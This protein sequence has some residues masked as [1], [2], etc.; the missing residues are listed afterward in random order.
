MYTGIHLYVSQESYL[1][2]HF[3]LSFYLKSVLW[4]ML[5]CLYSD[6]Y[7][8]YLWVSIISALKCYTLVV[9][10][11]LMICLICMPSAL[12]PAALRL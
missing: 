6:T 10:C 7:T 2:E 12:G 9:T 5:N 1:F 11:A 4:Q 8:I 3:D